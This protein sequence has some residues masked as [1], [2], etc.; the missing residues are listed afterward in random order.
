MLWKQSFT[1]MLAV[2][3][4]SMFIPSILTVRSF[5]HPIS[6]STAVADIYKDHVQV[7]LRILVEDLMFYHALEANSEQV[8]S[9]QDLVQAAASH[10]D[11]LARYFRVLTK[12][13]ITMQGTF[14]TVD[15]QEIGDQGVRL[16]QVMEVGVY[17][18]YR[19]QLQEI[20]DYLTFS[21]NFGGDNAPVP[22]VMDLILLQEGARMDFPVQIG[23]RS[24]HSVAINWAAPPRNDRMYWKE[25]REMMRKRREELLGITSFSS[26]YAYIYVEPHEIRFELLVPLLTLDTWLPTKRAAT[27]FLSVEEQ[28]GLEERLEA[29]LREQCQFHVDGIEVSPFLSRLDFFTLDIR[30]FAKASE[31]RPIGILNG[32]AGMIMTVATKGA[33]AKVSIEWKLFNDYTPLLNTM[34]YIRDKGGE[35][36]FFTENEPKW[37]WQD[38]TT[39]VG[40]LPFSELPSAPS[41]PVW[42]P[43]IP[44]LALVTF[45]VFA[46]S[47]GL[48]RSR[49]PFVVGGCS[50]MVLAFIV[51]PMTQQEFPHPFKNV[52][53]PEREQQ[54]LITEALLKNV[55]R[56]FDYR[57]DEHVYDALERSAS[58]AFLEKLYLQIKQG[59]VVEEQGGARARVREFKWL[60]GDPLPKPLEHVGFSL[61]VSWEV[62]GNVEH[63]GHVHTRQ[64]LYQAVLVIG[65]QEGQWKILGMEVRSVEPLKSTTGLRNAA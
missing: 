51:W 39:Q 56:A 22:A 34:V 12:E 5:A 17:Y 42:H 40:A 30:D 54:H 49:S 21:Q 25:R 33:P 43:S 1:A 8:L 60:S 26:T 37:S 28:T 13:G 10:Q 23:P 58:G 3:L 65:S 64:Q 41:A 27:D 9:R 55:Y 48:L 6:M 50:A 52:P 53:M 2:F 24:P 57:K 16:D 44:S 29:L 20:P 7:E 4:G 11:F 31:P 63:W 38:D 62:T 14:A 15:T 59:L 36:H 46:L 35:R 19:I 18:Q 47:Y 45:G 61:D 32:R